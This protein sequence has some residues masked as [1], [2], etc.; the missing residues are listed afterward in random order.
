MVLNH[1]SHLRCETLEFV[2]RKNTNSS[3]PC[4]RHEAF[5]KSRI[6]LC[7]LFR[8]RPDL[9]VPKEEP[10]ANRFIDP[11]F[12]WLRRL[13]GDSLR[14]RL[15]DFKTRP[16]ASRRV[17]LQVDAVCTLPPRTCDES[18]LSPSQDG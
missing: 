9:R 10:E 12:Q 1:D 6:A 15:L 16:P 3:K 13:T 2:E 7:A 8:P 4:E 11:S 14:R 5:R 17:V 18:R